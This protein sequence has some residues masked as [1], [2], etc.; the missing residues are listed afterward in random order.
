MAKFSDQVGTIY[1]QM[2][3]SL[4]DHSG[5]GVVVV[6]VDGRI[7]ETNRAFEA[8]HGWAKEELLGLLLTSTPGPLSAAK[9]LLAQAR[10]RS[11]VIGYETEAL[12]KD[13]STFPVSMSL[14][15]LQDAGGDLLGYVGIERRLGGQT[16][17]Q[18]G[19]GEDRLYHLIAEQSPE[20]ILALASG[21]IVYAN[22][23]AARLV[24]LESAAE[25]LGM[26]VLEWMSPAAQFAG[27]SAV[28]GQS[29]H[30]RAASAWMP[31]FF[32]H[33]GGQLL[34][35]SVRAVPL[36]QSGNGPDQLLYIRESARE[37]EG[38]A[39]RGYGDRETQEET[40]D[41]PGVQR[42]QRL[43]KFLPEPIVV[44]DQGLVIYANKSAL[45]LFRATNERQLIGKSFFDFIHKEYLQETR[46]LVRSVMQT[47]DPSPFK[48]IQMVCCDG[49]TIEA[50]HSNIRIHHYMG[51]T[52]T[53]TVL[54]DITDRKQNEEMM[55]RSEKL[56][57]IGQLAAGLAHEIRNPL[58]SLKGFTQLLKSRSK[59]DSFYFDTM[60]TEL[61]RIN[62]IV[63][64][65]MTLAKPQL[66]Q[67]G[68]GN[69]Y[70]ML[71]HVISVL[72]H[73]AVLLN[74]NL[75]FSASDSLPHIY[76][77]EN[78]LKQVFINLIKNAMEAMPEGGNVVISAEQTGPEM[79]CIKI[80]DQGEG[81]PDSIADKLG[82]PFL[83]TK[84]NGTG[85]GLM[86]SYR[87]MEQHH[88]KLEIR[89]RKKQGTTVKLL[90]PVPRAAEGI[91]MAARSC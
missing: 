38:G 36:S 70:A 8:M 64:D 75:I 26:H 20:P 6:D 2:L 16:Y 13:G 88:G 34:E 77:D 87:I 43:I 58:T 11:C 46:A 73:Q 82:E 33:A 12:H 84:T 4:M 3:E 50:E 32:S 45:K 35:A 10:K 7:V 57:I 5:D 83:T 30:G 41:G 40:E 29:P 65:F 51:K 22:P 61:E 25:L 42:Y 9:A 76:G 62:L 74:V 71:E 90:L 67:F 55:I 69:V 27:T 15:P 72:N 31:V 52:V 60:L 91:P 19:F 24:G 39:L 53:L 81:I 18:P 56:S 54:R 28:A 79:I 78:Q 23:A 86:I 17:R 80:K 59:E 1:G 14:S 49:Q 85:L 21:K 37:A 66:T 63:G 68:Y 48:E 44:S 47:D 89:S